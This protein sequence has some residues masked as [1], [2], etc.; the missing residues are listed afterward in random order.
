MIGAIIAVVVVVVII[1]IM[2]FAPEPSSEENNEE[3][4]LDSHRIY[5]NYRVLYNDGFLSQPFHFKTAKFYAEDF[6]GKVVPRNYDQY[7]PHRVLRGGK[8]VNV[9]SQPTS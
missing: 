9:L 7:G 1:L 4:S 6:G 5:G 8:W 2:L 3:Y